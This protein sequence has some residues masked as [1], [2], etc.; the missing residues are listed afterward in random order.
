MTEPNEQSLALHADAVEEPGGKLPRARRDVEWTEQVYYGKGCYVL[1]D[2]TTLRYYRLRPPEYTIYQM[3]DGE[4]TLEEVL[5][6]LKHRFPDEEYDAQAVMSFLIMLRGAGLLHIPGERDTD[7]LLKRK[8]QLTRKWYKRIMQEYLFFR[9]PVFDPD[10]LLNGMMRTVG[11]LIFS[12]ATGVLT[13][14]MLAGALLLVL[15]DVDKLGQAQPILSWQNMM[16]L[17]PSLLIIK[18]I[19][20]FGHGLSAKYY[21]SEVHE[22]GIL[23]LVFAPFFYCDVSDAWMIPA[24]HKRLWI[25]AG[26]VVVEVFLAGVATYVWAFTE[27]ATVINQFALNTMLAA[28]VNTIFFNGNPLLRFD[29]YYFL[30]DLVEIPNLKQK[31]SGYLW[32]LMQ[33]FVLGVENAQKPIDVDGRERLVLIYTIA[34]FLYRILIM[35][36]IIVIIWTFLEPYGFG[37][38]GAILTMFTLYTILVKPLVKFAGFLITQRHRVKV[39]LA[40]A[41]ILLVLLGSTSYGVLGYQVEQAVRAQCV[42][43]PQEMHLLYVTQPGFLRLDPGDAPVEDGQLVQRG[44]VLLQLEDPELEAQVEH[45]KL[46]LQKLQ[47]QLQA[48]ADLQNSTL[49]RQLSFRLAALQARY[50]QGAEQQ[51]R[52]TLRSPIDG[53]VQ[54]RGPEK[55]KNMA[56]RYVPMRTPLLGVYRPERF[57]AVAAVS[58]GDFGLIEEQLDAEIKLLSLDGEHF[59]S[60]VLEKAAQ[61][62]KRMS[63]P[64]FSTVYGGQVP[65][66]PTA[67]PE[68][69]LEPAEVTYEIELAIIDP[70]GRFRDG[71]VGKAKIII[72]RESLWGIFSRWFLQTLRPEILL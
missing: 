18:L 8:K 13:L 27:P 42:V 58:H 1:K 41:L 29:G 46:E 50:D 59:D 34:S 60:Q 62:V 37:F 20:E 33:R 48:A 10:K 31:G 54:W 19:H 14:L 70:Q 49:E 57:E 16:F 9:V 26:G 65:T 2:P 61:D 39:R 22:M 56:G 64:V 35:I 17:L 23:F 38:V 4:N 30:M 69:A 25:T 63:S 55:M 6:A 12:R 72:G 66:M 67:S 7:Y 11:P 40:T 51:G 68:E 15:N 52:L 47:V 53:V 24:K 5:A 36:G 44:Q 43:R 3:L 45:L 21:G 71:L 32:Y 28:S